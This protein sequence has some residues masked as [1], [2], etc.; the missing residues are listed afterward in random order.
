MTQ[1][2]PCHLRVKVEVIDFC[3][4]RR[5]APILGCDANSHHVGWGSL[6][7]NPKGGALLEHSGFRNIKSMIRSDFPHW[8]K[9]GNNRSY[10]CS[11]EPV[12]DSWMDGVTRIIFIESEA[13]PL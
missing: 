2:N 11:R 13:H 1:L 12:S 7:I 5:L 4:E 10:S 9:A 8:Q 6:D 3:M